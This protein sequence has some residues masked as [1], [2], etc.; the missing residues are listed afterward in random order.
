VTAALLRRLLTNVI[1][2]DAD[3][4]GLCIDYFPQVSARFSGGMDRVA[5]FNLLLE[6]ESAEAI[7]DALRQ[8][9]PERL[10]EHSQMLTGQHRKN[11]N[12]YRGLSAFETADAELFFGREAL[13]SVLWQH[14]R[15]LL[16][17]VRQPRLL[18]VLGPSGSGKSS[19][20]LAGL[21]PRIFREP[22]PGLSL[23]RSVVCK[24]GHRP[25]ESL[26]RALSLLEPAAA[27]LPL[28]QRVAAIDRAL[29]E[30]NRDGQL[31][32][33]RLFAETL[34][35]ADKSPLLVVAD[36]FEEV[37]AL[38]TE[39][40]ERQCFV[41][42]LLEAATAPGAPV[43]VLLTLRSDFFDE[44]RAHPTLNRAIAAQHVLVPVMSR[45][46]LV[47]AIAAPAQLMGSQLD[48]AV[49]QL[50][51]QETEG[52]PGALPL[53]QFAL[54]RIWEGM[55]A[56]HSAAA[57][58]S[59]YGGVGGALAGQAQRIFDG[60]SV[61][62]QAIAQ[63]AFLGL[64][65]LGEG[66]QDTR[67]R[68]A[69]SE[70]VAHGETTE[71]VEAVLRCFSRP[72][73]RLI[74][75]A[76]NLTQ[77][78]EVAEVTHE[79]L[80]DH[81]SLLHSWI[82]AGR[83]D[84]RFQRRLEEQA[85]QW[86]RLGRPPGALW[87]S[88]ELDLLRQ[89]AKRCQG[90][91]TRLQSTFL[92][93]SVELESEER[94]AREQQ[95]IERRH[96][97]EERR[98]E[99]R[100]RA[101]IFL[102]AAILAGILLIALGWKTQQERVA[103]KDSERAT[104]VA[105]GLSA[106]ALAGQRDI[107]A[108]IASI[109]AV[110]PA[111]RDHTQLPIEAEGGLVTAALT[112]GY[113]A[114]PPL[115]NQGLI[116]SAEFSPDGRCL[117]IAG[118]KGVAHVLD[119]E[120]GRELFRLAAH[121]APILAALFSPDGK[122]I[123]TASKDG[124]VRLFDG[125]TGQHRHTLS[126]HDASV[127]GLRFTRSGHLLASFSDDGTARLWNAS[128][129]TPLKILTGHTDALTSASFSPDERTLATASKDGTVRLF[130]LITDTRPRVLIGHKD[131]VTSVEYSADGRRLLTASYD[132]TVRFWD[133]STGKEL[134]QFEHRDPIV[135]G[136]TFSRN[137]RRVLSFGNSGVRLWNLPLQGEQ[138]ADAKSTDRLVSSPSG[139]QQWAMFAAE[140]SLVLS[141]R[142][143]FANVDQVNSD[144]DV[145]RLN[146]FSASPYNQLTL[147]RAD[148]TASRILLAE[149]DG[150]VRVYLTNS[151]GR[152]QSFNSSLPGDERARSFRFSSD[153]NKLLLESSLP[154][155]PSRGEPQTVVRVFDAVTYRQLCHATS[156]FF[157][158]SGDGRELF[159]F[160]SDRLRVI[161]AEKC[162][163][164]R[165]LPLTKE[166]IDRI[167]VTAV[168]GDGRFLALGGGEDGVL[169]FDVTS[170]APRILRTQGAASPKTLMT[171]RVILLDFSPD[172]L[173]LLTSTTSG[174]I[175]RWDTLSTKEVEPPLELPP[176]IS[177]VRFARNGRHFLTAGAA[178]IARVWST[179]PT[180]TELAVLEGKQS[181]SRA[182]F[183]NDG[184]RV[185]TGG[186]GRA[187][188]WEIKTGR[189]IYRLTGQ[190][191]I[192]LSPDGRRL[193]VVDAGGSVTL[194]SLELRDLIEDSCRILRHHPASQ[195]VAEHCSM[196]RVAGLL[197]TQR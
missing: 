55:L 52:R 158:V 151:V 99:L 186:R 117:L 30:P 196:I 19:V 73:A 190:R 58:L 150:T 14:Y 10:A 54:T 146:T 172:G 138:L 7:L 72:E 36:Q 171:A 147:A 142:D 39:P 81:W 31:T 137:S 169:L 122:Q 95:E 23:P 66:T 144:G 34:P 33:L 174:V 139:G 17:A 185:L 136:A 168:S 60:L 1:R 112:Y 125:T 193:A 43:V 75:L 59:A 107:K 40:T 118:V 94:A 155:D 123:A 162:A 101:R 175:Q 121:D 149:Q 170:P 179:S 164:R 111:L 153:G 79:A 191:F 62:E 89:F 84:I 154:S 61:R 77:D 90:S 100:L 143:S 131:R 161:D 45:E 106:S 18:A 48:A 163:M 187:Q 141:W 165:E 128:A 180:I 148:A 120:D 129:G 115:S 25:V 88:P 37:Y 63:R 56:G 38:C 188:L 76:W 83:D 28:F 16:A 4:E 27:E 21:L 8:F 85:R 152:Q 110:T 49:V 104:A 194:R 166:L 74:T 145:Q 80:F 91:L 71:Q 24:P 132:G 2:R 50:L 192:D 127:R 82:D 167:A 126:G 98:R 197:E 64:I 87:R 35:G 159:L 44:T 176:P 184:S 96:R 133:P 173:S 53:L 29:H 68:T 124:A 116:Y 189:E 57:T 70:L 32:G 92:A 5:K 26:A 195:E 119:T 134:G 178:G 182:R 93:A 177:A 13:T 157:D 113:L 6:L 67:R 3:L 12:P 46:E 114:W 103:R 105:K 140:D 181:V 65:Q 108:L 51:V 20:V 9:A 102:S 86:E 69:V 41:E 160:T 97:E 109:Q 11:Q 78:C 135:S 15:D 47:R 22:I 42:L 183:L 130:D 156:K